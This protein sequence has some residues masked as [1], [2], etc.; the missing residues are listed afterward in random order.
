[1]SIKTDAVVIRDETTTGANTATRVGTN[2]VDIADDLAA[3]QA[4][5]DLKQDK[6]L[7]GAFVDGDKTKL[8]GIT[9]GA[10]PDQVLPEI[11]VS[12]GLGSSVQAALD[13]AEAQ[14]GVPVRITEDIPALDFP[15]LMDSNQTLIFEGV[16]IFV[17]NGITGGTA[18][19]GTDPLGYWNS[20]AV[21]KNRQGGGTSTNPVVRNYLRGNSIEGGETNITVIGGTID[22]S[23]IPD[24]VGNVGIEFSYNGV[25]LHDVTNSRVEN[26]TFQSVLRRSGIEQGNVDV[27]NSFNVIVKNINA[28]DTWYS[29]TY[30]MDGSHIT[31]DGGYIHET[32]D[33]GIIAVNSDY[34]VIQNVYVDDCGQKPDG[35]GAS[36]ITSNMRFGKFI[37]NKSINAGL[38]LSTR[39]GSINAYG[40]TL[41]HPALYS[42]YNSIVSGNHFEGN[43]S[44]GVFLQGVGTINNIVSNNILIDNGNLNPSIN[45][46]G[47]N[48]QGVGSNKVIGNTCIGNYNGIALSNLTADSIIESNTIVDSTL[49]GINVDSATNTITK[50]NDI[51]NSGTSDYR[52]IATGS[53]F[54]SFEGGNL[55]ADN[56]SGTNTGHSNS[57]G[58]LILTV[59]K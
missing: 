12:D 39:G 59:A 46:G 26:V 38:Y 41:G 20:H 15:I 22:G 28:T 2:L 10:T 48:L 36:N 50:L 24:D 3:K 5:I 33:S 47:I 34:G 51:T 40:F 21:I 55:T 29:G 14:A 45:N 9:A 58:M 43:A 49:Y 6:P 53:T 32:G 31:I 1:M 37:N 25:Q 18:I 44:K 17:K 19:G 16:T 56:L 27:R 42:A 57:S 7:E 11:L 4:A 54:V 52:D 8:D 30:V 13:S 35:S 23:N